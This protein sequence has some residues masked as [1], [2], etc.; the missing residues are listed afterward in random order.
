MRPFV[1]LLSALLGLAVAAAGA[2]LALEVGWHW[3]RPASGPL[4]VPWPRWQAQL[5]ALGWDAYAVRV[6]AGVLA[7]AG[8]VLLLCALAA[9]NRAVRLTDPAGE[10]SVSTS[11][12]S[13]ARLVGLTVR[14]QD[15]VA[16]ATVTASARR[17]RVRAKSTLE[18][19]G[20]LRPRLLETVAALLDEVP[21]ARRPK[22]SVVVDSPKD[23]R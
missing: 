21:L 23:R 19:E 7:A 3:W 16:G 4:L 15:N 1:R 12:R 20:E 11:P 13:L 18:S 14:A 9:G 10:V 2:L 6:G 17:V 22:V 8:L 5:A